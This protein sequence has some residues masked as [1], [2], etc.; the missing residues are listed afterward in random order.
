ML[1]DTL[2]TVQAP[3]STPKDG[4]RTWEDTTPLDLER[5]QASRQA[6]QDFMTD[7]WGAVDAVAAMFREKDWDSLRA[8]AEAMPLKAFDG[9]DHNKRIARANW[10]AS[11]LAG[12]V[13]LFEA[14]GAYLSWRLAQPL[15]VGIDSRLLA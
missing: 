5:W 10:I 11:F 4:I 8:V 14:A 6:R 2:E 15:N 12:D 13:D 7:L 9:K 1:R 3:E